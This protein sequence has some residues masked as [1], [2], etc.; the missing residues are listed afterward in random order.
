[1]LYRVKNKSKF[2]SMLIACV[3]L[4]A[5]LVLVIEKTH[6]MEHYGCSDE[7]CPICNIAYIVNKELKNVSLGGGYIK[8]AMFMLIVFAASKNVSDYLCVKELSLV[9]C[10]IRLND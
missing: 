7:H 1:M 3:F 5:T 9:K 2:L 6:L 8:L 10:K 4:C